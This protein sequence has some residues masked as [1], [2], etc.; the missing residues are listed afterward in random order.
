MITEMVEYLK[1]NNMLA[2]NCRFGICPAEISV[3][4]QKDLLL[5][6][7]AGYKT[8]FKTN[9]F[10]F[11]PKLAEHLR[12]N[13]GYIQVSLDCGTKE[14]FALVKGKDLFEKTINNIRKYT[15]YGD[16]EI[17]YIIISGVN[18]SDND[19][20]GIISILKSL[21]LKRL[22]LSFDFNMPFR[23]VF[24]SLVK[25]IEKLT[26][27]DISFYFEPIYF[28]VS[29]VKEFIKCYY[30]ANSK[31]QYETKELNLFEAFHNKCS[32]DYDMYKEYVFLMEIK[33]LIGYFRGG[34]R[35]AL[36]NTQ[37]E[38]DGWLFQ[39]PKIPFQWIFQEIGIPLQ[40]VEF[41]FEKPFCMDKHSADIFICASKELFNDIKSH[42][43]T[44]SRKM[45]KFFRKPLHGKHSGDVTRLLDIDTYLY[46]FKPAKDFLKDTK[47]VC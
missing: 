42:I 17:K 18:N 26:E 29:E 1:R 19:I 11:D 37:T 47:Y 40:T 30:N 4:P 13:G 12:K 8:N 36:L 28:G 34:T 15:E 16:V 2:D 14:T 23:A 27:N 20:D 33:E 41:S 39:K 45:C 25:T 24:Y 38:H 7:A 9:A 32:A 5:E 44:E 43:E 6:A 3:L 31:S 21:G 10:L 46:T 22:C 35:F